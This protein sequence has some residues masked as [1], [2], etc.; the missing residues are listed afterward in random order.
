MDKTLV[1]NVSIIQRFHCISSLLGNTCE[2]ATIY[3]LSLPLVAT[4]PMDFMAIS[5]RNLIFPA[6]SM[7]GDTVCT[8]ININNDMVLEM[9]VEMFFLDITSTDADIAA[10]R[11]R[12]IVSIIETNDESKYNF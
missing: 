4:D 10:G 11:G 7:V 5:N 12:A 8:N 6:N 2:L 3:L 9:G 1:P